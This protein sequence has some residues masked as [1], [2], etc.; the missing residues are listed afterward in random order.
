[1]RALNRPVDQSAAGRQHDSSDCTFAIVCSYNNQETDRITLV[2][3]Q[4]FV[5]YVAFDWV[6]AFHTV[7][8]RPLDLALTHLTNKIR[9]CIGGQDGD[10]YPIKP[11][12]RA[13]MLSDPMA[14]HHNDIRC[15]TQLSYSLPLKQWYCAFECGAGLTRPLYIHSCQTRSSTC[16]GLTKATQCL[17]VQHAL[18]T[19]YWLSE[20]FVSLSC[21]HICTADCAGFGAATEAATAWSAV[22]KVAGHVGPEIGASIL[23][24]P[25]TPALGQ[26]LTAY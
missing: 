9:Y 11:W 20:I 16:F 3:L 4:M 26:P 18:I 19:L 10:L 12:H 24:G 21:S 25:L 5:M 2:C 7:C 6:C 14:V 13:V 15:S 23:R 17:M 1:M 22:T 8:N